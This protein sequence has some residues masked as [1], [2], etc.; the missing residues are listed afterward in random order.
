MLG[1]TC[2]KKGLSPTHD[3]VTDATFDM[4]AFVAAK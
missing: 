4:K 1:K 2:L 3:A